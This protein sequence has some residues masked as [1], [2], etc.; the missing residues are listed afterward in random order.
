MT[1]TMIIYSALP[2]TAKVNNFPSKH[3]LSQHYSTRTLLHRRNFDFSK[4]C[5]FSFGALFR[6]HDKSRSSN[7]LQFRTLDCIYLRPT[8]SWHGRHEL[9]LIL[10]NRVTTCRAITEFPIT[11]DILTYKQQK[12]TCL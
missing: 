12:K 11:H 1:R 4:H 3:V 2:T 6:A 7:T 9:L 5:K 8:T 10:T